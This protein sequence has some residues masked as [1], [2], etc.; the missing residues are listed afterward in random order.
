MWSE[1]KEG[2]RASGRFSVAFPL[3]FA[4]PVGIEFIQHVIEVSAGMYV[5]IEGAKAA[6]SDPLRLGW[7]M[8]KTLA[9][10]ITLYWMARFMAGF[11]RSRVASFEPVAVRLFLVVLAFNA[12][13]TA[14]FFWGGGLLRALGAGEAATMQIGIG[15]FIANLLLGIL[16]D[17]WK[18]GAALGNPALG[19]L[20]SVRMI[21]PHI[22][23]SL[24]FT[25]VMML[26]LM[27]VHYGIAGI[28]I[29]ASPALV[30]LLMAVDSLLVGYLAAVLAATSFLVA[31]RAAERRGVSLAGLPA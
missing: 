12:A 29:G 26:P 10:A 25:L 15:F 18:V 3:L 19:P 7:G 27:V 4:I 6:E 16:L 2:Y 1:I 23:W 9:I 14:L 13:L 17:G 5:N 30:W 28:A 31:R 22:A 8:V 20:R 11:E 21:A 24:A